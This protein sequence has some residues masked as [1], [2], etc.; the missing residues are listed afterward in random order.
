LYWQAICLPNRKI[1]KTVTDMIKKNKHFGPKEEEKKEGSNEPIASEEIQ[2]K[3]EEGA[4]TEN[5]SGEEQKSDE[6]SGT[7]AEINIEE[8]YQKQVNE[9]QDKYM[10]L[11]AEFDNYRKRT[12]KERME[13]MK[14]AGEDILVN[15]LPVVDDF[16]RGLQAME[17]TN[18]V[19]ALKQGVS[20]IY[21][22]FRDLLNQRG[23][24]EIEAV[25]LN[26]NSDVH[27]AITKIPAPEEN[28]KGK[29]IDVVLKG[30]TMN[31]KVIRFAKVVVGE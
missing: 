5:M 24:K 8:V 16:E 30:Y 9:L 7:T 13:L 28:L 4:A 25:N 6:N 18:D 11:M 23:V 10:R 27:E 2:N 17:R 14:T 29:V 22:K 20:L 26:F 31:E 15:L 1:K 3:M 21:S 19:E 12:L